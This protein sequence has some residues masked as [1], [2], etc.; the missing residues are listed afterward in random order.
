MPLDRQA[1]RVA[2]DLVDPPPPPPPTEKEL[3]YERA[4]RDLKAFVRLAWDTVVPDQPLCWNWHHDEICEK[5]MAVSRG[6]VKRLIINIPPGCSKTL[7]ASV[8]WP[9]WE[10]SSNPS[11]RYLTAAYSSKNTVRDNRQVRSIVTSDWYREAYGLVLASDQSAKMRFDTASKGWRIATSVEGEGTGEHPDRIII[12]DPLKAK[13]VKSKSDLQRCRDWFDGTISTRI[14]RDPAIVLIMQ[15]LHEDDLAGHLLRKGILSEDNRYGW[16]HLC[17]PMYFREGGWS[18]PCHESASDPR[19]HRTEI[20]ELLWPEVY[21]PERLA[22]E[23]VNLSEFG[24]A[25]QLQQDPQPEGGGLV[26]RE[27]FEGRFVESAPSDATRCRGW[28]IAE[29]DGGGNYTAGVRL[30]RKDGI[31]YV[32]HAVREQRTLV[33]GLLLATAESDGWTCKVRE[34]SGS[35]KATIAARSQILAKYDY[36]ASPETDSKVERFSPFRGQ[37]EAGNVRIVRGEWN[38]VWLDEVCAFPVGRYDDQVD[39]TS[40]AY[41]ELVKADPPRRFG[42]WGRRA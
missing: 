26:K 9:S 6:E 20:G 39:A 18:C 24:V 8:F 19:D 16:E 29:T 37:C 42:T 21:G 30:S 25:G 3:R 32:E 1:L 15:R 36:A 40:N 5:L 13:G 41:N 11:L 17:F 34:G 27:W 35:G 38:E 33:D 10:W 2:A 4:R 22:E 28:D 23:E 7:L 31:T 12:D 14:Q